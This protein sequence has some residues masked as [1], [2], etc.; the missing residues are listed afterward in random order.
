MLEKYARLIVGYCTEVQPG[1]NVSLNVETPALPLARALTREVLRAGA[2]PLLRLTYPEFVSDILELGS[3]AQFDGEPTFDL[4]E[5][6]QV[7]AWIRV[8]APD[9]S[10]ELQN[11]DKTLLARRMKRNRPVQNVRLNETRWLGTIFPTPAG[12]QDAGMSNDEFREFAYRAMFLYED[13][14][15]SA[16]Q[17]QFDRQVSLVE[18][19]SRADEVHIKGPGTDLKLSVKGRKW[20]NSAGK[21]NMPCGEVFTGPVESSAEGVITYDIP[22]A[23]NGVEVRNIRLRFE[24]GKVVEAHAEKGDDLLQAQLAADPGARY[25]G[26]LGIGTN[27]QI[28]RPSM[29]ILYDE[30]IGGTVHL[31]L[32]QSYASTGG[33]N[34]SAIHWDMITDLRG[35]GAIYLDGELFQEDGQFKL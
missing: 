10:R 5:I 18:R 9:N 22:S 4:N 35:G 13:D 16:G 11:A 6:R 29:S 31:A 14:P 20:E 32:G 33:V 26:E 24:Q 19:L 27:Y 23:V 7:D 1:D 21:R 12:A 30:K 15:P 17:A 25:L 8:S 34:E 2:N 28:Q 3:D